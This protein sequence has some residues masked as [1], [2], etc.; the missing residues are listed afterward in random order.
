MR[1][2]IALMLLAAVVLPVAADP[3]PV[4]PVALSVRWSR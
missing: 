1:L 3:G 4:V 2:I